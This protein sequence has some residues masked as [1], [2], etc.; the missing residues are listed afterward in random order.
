MNLQLPA[1]HPP[2]HDLVASHVQ[3][4]TGQGVR[5][6]A[7]SRVAKRH[8]DDMVPG[9][10][11]E[12]PPALPQ[13]KSRSVIPASSSTTTRATAVSPVPAFAELVFEDDAPAPPPETRL[14]PGQ[15]EKIVALVDDPDPVRG[16]ERLWREL[17]LLSWTR[18]AVRCVDAKGEGIRLSEQDHIDVAQALVARWGGRDMSPQRLDLLGDALARRAGLTLVPSS[19]DN[20]MT[21]FFYVVLTHGMPKA[22]PTVKRWLARAFGPAHADHPAYPCTGRGLVLML[23]RSS[24]FLSPSGR[25]LAGALRESMTPRRQWDADDARRQWSMA[26]LQVC[27]AQVRFALDPSG[28][29]VHP[30]LLDWVCEALLPP[31]SAYGSDELFALASGL[32]ARLPQDGMAR[33]VRPPPDAWDRSLGAEDDDPLRGDPGS[34]LEARPAWSASPQNYLGL[35]R[36]VLRSAGADNARQALAVLA[37]SAGRE[38]GILD[39]WAPG[40]G[41][42]VETHFALRSRLCRLPGG[43]DRLVAE[44]ADLLAGDDIAL[45]QAFVNGLVRWACP[46]LPRDHKSRKQAP[47]DEPLALF[48]MLQTAVHAVGT[49]WTTEGIAV[50]GDLYARRGRGGRMTPAETE[51]LVRTWFELPPDATAQDRDRVAGLRQV[52]RQG[53]EAHAT[54]R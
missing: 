30:G 25:D 38:H 39:D 24:A 51:K 46:P 37:M 31:A 32:T 14:T 27:M 40:T 11:S 45:C 2:A 33:S 13:R 12:A 16:F 17:G 52:L 1:L 19:R 44:T 3:A 42:G 20:E 53:L 5:P 22:G 36:T 4:D 28:G 48:R 41:D 43:L 49:R 34:G 26:D 6:Q 8:A 50:L 9:Q 15:V 54:R 10:D 23:V 35:V 47:A 21:R 7:T 29:P 18:D